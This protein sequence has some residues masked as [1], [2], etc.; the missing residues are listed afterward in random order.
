MAKVANDRG[1]VAELGANARRLAEGF[2]WEEAA[3]QTEEHLE[4]VAA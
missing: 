2:S 3:R 4:S 1:L